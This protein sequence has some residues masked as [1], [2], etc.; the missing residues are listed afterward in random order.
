MCVTAYII[1]HIGIFPVQTVLKLLELDSFP[2]KMYLPL[3]K[4]TH[5]RKRER[6]IQKD[7]SSTGILP[8]WPQS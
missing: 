1:T 2:R 8:K 5:H 4:K 7:G 3:F 6:H